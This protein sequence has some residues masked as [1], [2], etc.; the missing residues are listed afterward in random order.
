MKTIVVMCFAALC[1]LHSYAQGQTSTVNVEVRAEQKPVNG[2]EVTLE[3]HIHKTDQQGKVLVAAIPGTVDLTVTAKGYIPQTI[4]LTVAIGQASSVTVDLVKDEEQIMVTATRTNT[5]IE[6]Q[7]TRVEVLD[8]EEVEEKMLMTPGDI[9][10]MLNEMGGLRVQ[11]TSP[12]LGAASVR[13]QGMRGR[14]TR[15]LSDGLPLF[16]QQVGGLGLL[17]I[18]PMDL[19]QVEVIKGVSSALYGAGAMAGVVDLISRRP[20]KEAL[21]DLL[22]NQTSRGGTDAVLFLAAPLKLEWFLLGRSTL[23]THRRY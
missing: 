13:I 16:G 9:T 2:A 1:A 21:K 14:Y 3:G 22:I 12:S 20:G 7:P 23:S 18:P 8:R 4:S 19:A 11:A 5:R 6:D 17:Q 10:M 15:F